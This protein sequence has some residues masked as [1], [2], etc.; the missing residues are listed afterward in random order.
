MSA[1]AGILQMD[2]GPVHIEDGINMMNALRKF[3]ADDAGIWHKQSVLLG[4][5]AQ[6]IT[7]ESVGEPLPYYDG[8]RQLAITADAIIDNREELFD[9]LNIERD[10]RKSIPDSQLILLAYAKWGEETPKRLVGDFAFMIWDE[11]ERTLFGARDFSGSRTLYYYLDRGASR[12]AFCTVIRPL[13][14]LPGIRTALNEPWLAEFL[15]IAGM[16][17][18]ADSRETPYADVR[19]LPPAHIITIAGHHVTLKRYCMLTQG[20]PLRFARDEQYVEAFQDVFQQAVSSRLRTHRSVG[21]QLSGGLDSGSV[22]GFA[23][24]ELAKENKPLHTFS[25]IPESDFVDYTPKRLMPDERPLIESTVRHVGG[26]QPHYLAFPG[27][28]SYSEIESMLEITEMPYKFYVNSFWLRG[29]FEQAQSQDVGILLNGGRG[30]LSISWGKALPYYGLLLK[31][32]KWLKLLSEL[33]KYSVN[34]GS[35][36]KHVLSQLLREQFPALY[37]LPQH[38]R[39]VHKPELAPSLINPEFAEQTNVYARLRAQGI[40]ESGRSATRNP[41]RLRKEH[42][43]QLFQWNA[44]NS[45]SAKLSLRHSLW[46][47]DPTND[48]RVIKYCLSVPEEQYVRNGLDRALIRRATEGLL[49]DNVRLNQKVRGVQGAD[50]VHR[51]IPKRQAFTEEAERMCR[52]EQL[53]QFVNGSVLRNAFAELQAGG[54]RPEQA[55]APHLKVLMDSLIVYRFIHHYV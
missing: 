6:W 37:R 39:H 43:E 38:L 47:R 22:V 42:F 36:R 29:M 13:L 45:L 4:C 5:R 3:P 2:H 34:I 35:G 9:R 24:K 14:A 17:D 28:D 53:A 21:S 16:V 52:D 31:R 11:R 33:R 40:D 55:Y 15:V 26:I 51:I 18:A 48:L 10:L 12:F 25:Y 8:T 46:K 20:E 30:N 44:S 41:Y 19:Q 49:P 32:L 7:P 1:I 50:W 54:L 27:K 23:A